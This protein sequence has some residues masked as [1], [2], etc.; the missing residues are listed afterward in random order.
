MVRILLSVLGLFRTWTVVQRELSEGKR[1]MTFYFQGVQRS[2]I[3]TLQFL[4]YVNGGSPG[5]N[6]SGEISTQ[7]HVRPSNSPKRREQ[8]KGEVD[9]KPEPWIITDF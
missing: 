8:E 5:F 6:A 1:V 9:A 7:S 2:N 4:I 3:Y